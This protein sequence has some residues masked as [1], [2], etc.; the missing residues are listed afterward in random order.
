MSTIGKDWN[1]LRQKDIYG[2]LPQDD[3]LYNIKEKMRK[4][5]NIFSAMKKHRIQE[6]E[7][8][9]NLKKEKLEQLINAI[10][11]VLLEVSR[12]NAK[13]VK[14]ESS[15]WNMDALNIDWRNNIVK[16]EMEALLLRALKEGTKLHRLKYERLGSSYCM[17]ENSQ[18]Q[19]SSTILGEKIYKVDDLFR[20]F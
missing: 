1:G 12:E 7:Q 10:E 8:A 20:E 14:G 17:I 19:L 4:M 2:F 9:E 15:L 18:D 16:P 6:K 3:L 13:I 11:D 5:C